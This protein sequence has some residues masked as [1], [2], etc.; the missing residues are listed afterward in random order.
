V[1]EGLILGMQLVLFFLMNTRIY[2]LNGCHRKFEFLK[3]F[4]NSFIIVVF[5]EES[6]RF[7]P[8]QTRQH[9]ANSSK[10]LFVFEGRKWWFQP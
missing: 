4:F 9:A 10:S 6:W 3:F 2:N 7:S 8:K 1:Y 5:R